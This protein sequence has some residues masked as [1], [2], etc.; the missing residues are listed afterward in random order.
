M[1]ILKYIGRKTKELAEPA[2]CALVAGLLIAMKSRLSRWLL[3]ETKPPEIAEW[4]VLVLAA[5]LLALAWAAILRI[6]LASRADPKD[7]EIYHPNIGVTVYRQK[8]SS[9]D[10]D[11]NVWYCPRCLTID[12]KLAHMNARHDLH[13]TWECIECG[14]TVHCS[15]PKE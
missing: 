7:Y 15:P 12:H 13:S 1:A 10:F 5:L 9:K 2:A 8:E 3:T 11:F 6:R 14:R 4:I